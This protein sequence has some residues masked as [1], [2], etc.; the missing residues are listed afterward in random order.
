MP[1]KQTKTRKDYIKRIKKNTEEITQLRKKPIR[2]IDYFDAVLD[3][4]RSSRKEDPEL[5]KKV[6]LALADT[7]KEQQI[8]KIM[9]QLELSL[10]DM[11]SIIRNLRMETSNA[12]EELILEGLSETA[13]KTEKSVEATESLKYLIDKSNVMSEIRTKYGNTALD[14]YGTITAQFYTVL[15]NASAEKAAELETLR[16]TIDKTRK[17]VIRY[18]E[19]D[20]QSIPSRTW[21]QVMLKA[22]DDEAFGDKIY[23]NNAKLRE[24]IVKLANDDKFIEKAVQKY[25]DSILYKIYINAGINEKEQKRI[26]KEVNAVK[27][28]KDKKIRSMITIERERLLNDIDNYFNTALPR[29][30]E[31]ENLK[32]NLIKHL[33]SY[34]DLSSLNQITEK[35]TD[36]IGQK[37]RSDVSSMKS[38]SSKMQ[39]IQKEKAD[40]D[41][42]KKIIRGADERGI[43]SYRSL[44]D[45][46]NTGNLRIAQLNKTMNTIVNDLNK[47]LT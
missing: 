35:T 25:I 41:R 34:T 21:R 22:I 20:I 7:N 1:L 11:V 28:F 47:I 30:D 9:Q 13:E 23:L 42:A 38:N 15:H 24:K 18:I 10:Q 17:A 27:I 4:Y 32:A 33:V 39:T 26:A 29:I 3:S 19:T 40:L 46:T 37:A 45:A 2:G 44:I 14:I 5:A 43:V 31:A 12:T 16:K 36:K 6:Q 8:R